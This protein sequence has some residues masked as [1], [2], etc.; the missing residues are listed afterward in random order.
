MIPTRAHSEVKPKEPPIPRKDSPKKS[1]NVEPTTPYVGVGSRVRGWSHARKELG[2]EDPVPRNGG[3][4]SEH[5]GDAKDDD[6]STED[7]LL[8]V[9]AEVSFTEVNIDHSA[10]MTLAAMFRGKLVSC[11]VTSEAAT[12]PNFPVCGPGS[13]ENILLTAAAEY[14]HSP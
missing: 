7:L 6:T 10:V 9:G 5:D 1:L 12:H 14:W 8:G 2:C 13:D 4:R 3:G 11:L